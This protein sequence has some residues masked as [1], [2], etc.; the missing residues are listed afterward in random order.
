MVCQL[1]RVN[2]GNSSLPESWIFAGGDPEKKVPIIFSLF[3]IR[4]EERF[5]L[6]DAGC[7]TM[8][9]FEMTDF[10]GPVAALEKLGVK[11]EQITDLII[12]HAHHDHMECVGCYPNAVVYLHEQELPEGQRYLPKQARVELFRDAFF[13]AE[14][15][16]VVPIG[17]H[18]PGSCIVEVQ[19]QGKTKVLCGDECYSF[20][21]LCNRIPTAS[22][23]CPERSRMFIDTYATDDY[24]C[25]LCHEE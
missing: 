7:V 6:V 4:T 17:G 10:I 20:Y 2:F 5:I 19:T 11:P 3:L 1:Q 25:L 22:S 8:D 15:I 13:L 12:T 16:R 23:F 21:N 14:G 18:S 24:E 9:G